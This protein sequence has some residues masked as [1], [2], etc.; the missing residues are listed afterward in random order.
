M[1]TPSSRL[2]SSEPVVMFSEPTNPLTHVPVAQSM[3]I[4]FAWMYG[5]DAEPPPLTTSEM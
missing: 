1:M 3:R 2:Y 5:S 4:V